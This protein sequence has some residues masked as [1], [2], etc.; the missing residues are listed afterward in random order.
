M[1]ATTQIDGW[2]EA[3]GRGDS[4]AASKLLATY[5]PTLRAR[6]A[7]GLGPQLKGKTEPEDILQQVY[8]QVLG[9]LA[10]FEPRG[11]DS[12]LNWVLTILDHRLV[13]AHR[14]ATAKVRDVAREQPP[15]VR[16]TGDSCW[17]L[18]DILYTDDATPSRVFRRE[19]AVGAL[20][21]CVA[22]LSKPHRQVIQLRFLQGLSVADVAGRLQKTEGA[23]VALTKRALEGLRKSMDHLGEFTRGG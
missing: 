16:S 9:Q 10:G 18:L 8:V 11:P 2:I 3:A 15:P 22:G 21:G 6:A 20:L 5:H 1:A 13:D 14:A 12:F 4:L 7:A 23:V 19:E 17:D